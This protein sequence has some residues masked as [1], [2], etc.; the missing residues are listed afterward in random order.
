MLECVCRDIA[1]WKAQGIVPGRISVNF[2][3]HHLHSEKLGE[4][5]IGILDKYGVE[6]EFIPFEGAWHDLQGCPEGSKALDKV[7]IEYINKY[8]AK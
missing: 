2:S 1:A 3:K 8:L 7:Y 4:K 5:I 6:H